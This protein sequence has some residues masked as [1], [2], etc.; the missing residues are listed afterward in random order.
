MIPAKMSQSIRPKEPEHVKRA[1]AAN[2]VSPSQTVLPKAGA[3]TS[4]Q[5]NQP[6]STLPGRAL[7]AQELMVR[8][9]TADPRLLLVPGPTPA[10]QSQT[11]GHGYDL[12]SRKVQPEMSKQVVSGTR[13]GGSKMPA[14]SGTRVRDNQIVSQSQPQSHA[15]GQPF[16]AAKQGRASTGTPVPAPAGRRIMRE[17]SLLLQTRCITTAEWNRLIA[18]EGPLWADRKGNWRQGS[19]HEEI[20]EG[21]HPMTYEEFMDAMHRGLSKDVIGPL[22]QTREERHPLYWT[23]FTSL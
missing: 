1:K 8:A 13:G 14:A 11:Q 21:Y 7:T 17:A 9:G 12:R 16:P 10:R 15:S 19:V 5:Q 3:N 23:T 6:S 2:A 22:P 4:Q 20:P 18:Q